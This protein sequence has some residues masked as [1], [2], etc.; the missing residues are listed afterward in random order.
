[1]LTRVFYYIFLSCRLA[2][3]L[4][5]NITMFSKKWRYYSN[6]CIHVGIPFSFTADF[7]LDF[8]IFLFD[9]Q[10]FNV[11]VRRGYN[12][13]LNKLIMGINEFP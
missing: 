1:M 10:D 7:V 11:F 9:N 12:D 3:V 8:D 6:Y 4:V 13:I 2:M 5:A